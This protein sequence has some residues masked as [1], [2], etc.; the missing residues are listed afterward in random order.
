M[1]RKLALGS[2]RGG[3]SDAVEPWVRRG[4]S[5]VVTDDF[6]QR[7]EPLI[8][9]RSRPLDKTFVRKPG[10]GRPPKPARQVFEA[11]MYVLRTG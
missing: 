9:A 7:E 5:P 1:N 4:S 6:W 3:G 10:G 8:P 11:V 2:G